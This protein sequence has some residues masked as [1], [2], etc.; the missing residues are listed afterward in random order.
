MTNHRLLR[1]LADLILSFEEESAS[2]DG[3]RISMSI[4]F[5]TRKDQPIEPIFAWDG[6]E[7][8]PLPEAE[9]VRMR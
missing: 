5:M 4:Q 7:L 8:S 2:Y 9:K 3:T 1:E 6:R